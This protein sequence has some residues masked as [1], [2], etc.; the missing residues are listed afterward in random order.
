MPKLAAIISVHAQ[1][2]KIVVPDTELDVDPTNWEWRKCLDFP[3][4]KVNELAFSSKPYKWIRY[5]TGSVVGARGDLCTEYDLH[6]P[7]PIDYDSALSTVSIDLYYHTSDSEKSRMFPI[8]PTLADTSTTTSSR[9][10][11]RWDN[12][13]A[14]VEDR[15]E[16]CVVTG[17][18]ALCCTA[19]NLLPY[20]KGDTYIESF[21]THRRRDSSGVDDIV[22]NIDDIR[23]GLFLTLNLRLLLGRNFALLKT[24]NFAMDTTDVDSNADK[25]QERFTSHFFEHHYHEASLSGSAARIPADKSIRPPDALFDA[26][27]ASAVLH[28]FGVSMNET[29]VNWRVV[30]YPGWPM[31]AADVDNKRRCDQADA[32]KEN[33]DVQKAV[34]HPSYKSCDEEEEPD[35]LTMC[36]LQAMSPKQARAYLK[37]CDEVAAAK[38]RKGL[39][40]KVNSWRELLPNTPPSG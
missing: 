24:P 9:T 2:P 14:G 37:G 33:C 10:S 19:V 38:W 29:L 18:F 17:N 6:S 20:S 22:R 40:E 34:G 30:F 26:V 4:S 21:S 16:S 15:D 27:Y 36:R 12:F 39:A 1:F 25:A 28:H 32:D 8:D 31:K 11:T 7:V 3:V 5:A 13:R 23:N 35:P